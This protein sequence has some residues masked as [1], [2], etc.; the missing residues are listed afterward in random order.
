MDQI[1]NTGASAAAVCFPQLHQLQ[2]RDALEQVTRRGL[3]SL[4]MEEMTGI[5]VSDS[6]VEPAEPGIQ[7]YQ[8]EILR[9]VLDAPAELMSPAAVNRIIGQDMPVL[10]EHR[11][12]PGGVDDDEVGTSSKASIF[13]RA[14]SWAVPLFA[15]MKVQSAAAGLSGGTADRHL[16]ALEHSNRRFVNRSE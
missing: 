7:T 9:N 15:I 10:L 1:V 3:Y 16:V 5:I 11:A 8:V 4:A 14:R 13:L 2:S 12:A 6:D